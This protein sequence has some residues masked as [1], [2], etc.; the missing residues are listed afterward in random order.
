MNIRLGNNTKLFYQYFYADWM[1]EKLVVIV[2]SLWVS[3]PELGM[4]W[5]FC[6]IIFIKVVNLFF[7]SNSKMMSPYIKSIL[8][9][10]NNS[11]S[12]LC[13]FVGIVITFYNF[14]IFLLCVVGYFFSR[15]KTS[16]NKP[17][18]FTHNFQKYLLHQKWKFLFMWIYIKRCSYYNISIF[19][20]FNHRK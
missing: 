4:C 11:F 1:K 15:F 18:F 13:S 3:L 10:S 7:F 20:Y 2:V 16:R 19:K 17:M 12:D 8:F 14:S 5:W 9:M 6:Y